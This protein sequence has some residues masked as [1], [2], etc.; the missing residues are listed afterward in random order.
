MGYEAFGPREDGGTFRSTNEASAVARVVDLPGV[1]PV[2]DDPC[3]APGASRS[4]CGGVD[5]GQ[6]PLRQ[7][8]LR[9]LW[10]SMVVGDLRAP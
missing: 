1:Q 10:Q 5:S 2:P 9:L 6:W 8:R 3:Y 7:I 4:G